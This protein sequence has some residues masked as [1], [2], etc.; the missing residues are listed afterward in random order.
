MQE[1]FYTIVDAVD[2]LFNEKK[3]ALKESKLLT[4]TKKEECNNVSKKIAALKNYIGEIKYLN[5]DNPSLLI[6]YQMFTY[7]L[8]IG[9]F[10]ISVLSFN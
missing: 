6:N 4:A 1:E 5:S 8:S 3:Q 10:I 7:Y 9:H 2:T